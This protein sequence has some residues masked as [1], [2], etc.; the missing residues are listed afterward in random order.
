MFCIA[1]NRS[2]TLHISLKEINTANPKKVCWLYIKIIE[3]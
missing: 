3:Q 2:V 1:R